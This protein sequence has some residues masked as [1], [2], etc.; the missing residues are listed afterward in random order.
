MGLKP[1]IS[2]C[3][4]TFNR[5]GYL[6]QTL[7]SI[8][9][10]TIKPFQV[11]IVDNA[12]TDNT[13]QIAAKYKKLGFA[14][15][16]NPKN[17]GMVG[18]YNRCLELAQGNYLSFLHSD[19]LISSTWQETWLETIP[20]YRADYYTSSICVINKHNHPLFIY[21]TFKND[22]LLPANEALPQLLRH[23]CP[24]IAPTGAT[25]FKTS[26]LKSVAPFKTSLGTEADV[27]IFLRLSLNHSL[28]YKR[29]VLFYHRSHPEQTFETKKQ[30]KSASDRLE[31]ITNYFTIVKHFSQTQLQ[32]QPYQRLFILMNVFMTLCSPRLYLSKLKLAKKIFP[33]LFTQKL[34][35]QIFLKVQTLFIFRALLR[36]IA[37]LRQNIPGQTAD[38]LPDER[39]ALRPWS[40][41]DG[42]ESPRR[43]WLNNQPQSVY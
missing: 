43:H 27:D 7:Q 32:N 8:V 19:D 9:N 23:Y 24:I 41:P 5:A 25:V 30:F 17:L 6:E 14:Y 42:R 31:K 18:N 13:L 36:P 12:S 33:D 1:T 20:C 38:Q 40:R 11:L 39:L 28:F 21:H 35:W 3:I 22:C 16:R 2:I 4:P 10:Q 37:G 15:I 29:Q 34:D 26:V